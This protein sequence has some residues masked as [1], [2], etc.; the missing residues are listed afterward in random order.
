LNGDGWSW[1]HID[2]EAGIDLGGLKIVGHPATIDDELGCHLVS[3]WDEDR[4]CFKAIELTGEVNRLAWGRQ[5][6]GIEENR[7]DG[8]RSGLPVS[9]R[10]RNKQ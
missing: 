1:A 6:C 7:M 9:M 3:P 8:R 2:D 5:R 4:E 10:G